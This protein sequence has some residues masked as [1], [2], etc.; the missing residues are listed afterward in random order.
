MK[1]G[2]IV[3]AGIAVTVFSAVVGAITCG[4]IFNWV[5][6]VEPT[7]VWKPME[8]APGATVFIGLFI[9]NVIIAFVYALLN[10]GIPGGN[11]VV[12]GIVFGLCV[13]AVGVL[14]GMFA[15]HVFMTVAT[16]FVVYTLIMALIMS[17]LKGIIIAA[18]YGE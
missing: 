2:R 1:I 8:G 15:T 17:P 10:K 14:P 18:I 4:G 6:Q 16:A 12:K 9:L 7:D 13:W 3:I 11:K 5:Y